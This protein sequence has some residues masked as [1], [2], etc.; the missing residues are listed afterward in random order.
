[1]KKLLCIDSDGCAIDSMNTKHRLCF[2]P[3]LYE[4]WTFSLPDEE[5]QRRWE[6]INLF[7]AQRG[8]NRF[9]GAAAILRRHQ[10]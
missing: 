6:K 2:G 3:A 9:A 5:V 7:S 10:K 4:V 1:M 8:I